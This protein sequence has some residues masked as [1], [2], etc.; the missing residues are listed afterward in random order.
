VRAL[1]EGTRLIVEKSV[2]TSL[3]LLDSSGWSFDLCMTF[4]AILSATDPVAV[5]VLMVRYSFSNFVFD[6]LILCII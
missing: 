2:L 6:F 3:F 1:E 4:G 5:S